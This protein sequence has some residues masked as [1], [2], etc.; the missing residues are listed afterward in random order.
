LRKGENRGISLIRYAD[1]V[2]VTAPSREV[3]EQY[4]ASALNLTMP[5]PVDV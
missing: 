1:D 3:L 5:L 4:V 2:A